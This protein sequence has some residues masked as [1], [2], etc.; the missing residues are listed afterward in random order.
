MDPTGYHVVNLLLHI[1]ASLLL[2]LILLRL[3]IPGAYLAALLFAVHPVNVESVAWIA[4]LKNTLSLLFFLLSIWCYLKRDNNACNRW[5]WLSLFAFL[6][7][8]LSKGSAAILPLVLLLI[9][10][11]QRGRIAEK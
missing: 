11:W 2:W 5:Y 3:Q 10:W 7:A 8:L 1:A 6:A 4:Q 9:A